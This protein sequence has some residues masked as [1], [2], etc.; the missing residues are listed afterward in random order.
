MER[1]QRRS[2]GCE[3]IITRIEQISMESSL[4]KKN[5]PEKLLGTDKQIQPKDNSHSDTLNSDCSLPMEDSSEN[6]DYNS[7]NAEDN[8]NESSIRD[9][10]IVKESKP[11]DV[12]EAFYS[13]AKKYWSSIEPTVDGMLGGFER[14]DAA[15][16]R[17]SRDYLHSMFRIK[18]APRRRI[19]LDCGAGIGRVTK[20]VLMPE[21]DQVDAVE[22]DKAFADKIYKFVGQSPKLG[23]VFN[24]GLQEFT[25]EPGKYDLIWTQWVLGHLTD[26]DLIAFFKR[27]IKGLSKNGMIIIKENVTASSPQAEIDLADSSVTRPI[28]H[29]KQLIVRSGLR[30]LRV[31][32]QNNF[33]SGILPVYMITAKPA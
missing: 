6:G 21:Y 26:D 32:L 12:K 30:I 5:V 15:D 16:V 22:Q 4:E 31:S 13:D 25:P 24:Q 9:I 1:C 33:P 20:R 29:L 27:C 11:M 3:D 17:G 14:L 7:T 18:P 2:D 28:M 8:L 23:E 10:E 19:A